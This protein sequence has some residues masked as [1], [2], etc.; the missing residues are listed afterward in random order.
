VSRFGIAVLVVALAVGC[1]R[2]ADEVVPYCSVD[3]VFAEPIL[4][5]F[6]QQSGVTVRGVFDTEETKST[7]V[8][9]RL[10]AEGDHPQADVFWSG[11]PVRV[12][13]LVRRG[14]V[15][16]YV[17]ANASAVP[18]QFKAADGTWT[19]VGARARVLLVNT[20]KVPRDAMP[21][22]LDALVDARWRGQ[23]AIANPLFGTTTMH[24]AALFAVWGEPKA[25]AFFAGLR[26]NEARVASSNGEVKR[27]VV[28][29]EVAFGLLD[30]DDAAEA[31]ADG[32]AVEVVYPDQD[33]IG[34]LVMP[35]TVVLIKNAPHPVAARRLIDALVSK[36]TEQQLA[37]SGH[38]PLRAD[39]TVATGVT[40]IAGVRAMA[41]DYAKV[42]TEMERIQP[43]L[44]EWVG[45]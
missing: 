1:R 43:W 9:N 33:G 38:M 31:I 19:G 4:R 7:G 27:L 30:T 29:G 13:L 28:A 6:E 45:L 44:R 23:V 8:V 32:A 20:K 12:F 16:P 5:G 18:A 34:T 2:G 41:V 24:A 42:A 15:E 39:V 37:T 35:T 21:R 36:E 26:A 25:K 10:I 40:R 17:P 22:S 11:D 14:L 3:Q